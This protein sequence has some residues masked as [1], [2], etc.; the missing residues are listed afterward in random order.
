M[1][2]SIAL[3]L[4][5]PW[6]ALAST[7]VAITIDDLPA[8]GATE[9]GQSRT[10]LNRALID[11][12]AAQKIG[13]VHAFING[14][15][16]DLRN[17]L[18]QVLTDWVA[19][20]HKVANHTHRHIDINGLSVEEYFRDIE[21]DEPLIERLSPSLPRYF[22]FPDLHEGETLPKRTA[23]RN[24]LK[25]RGYQLAHVTIDSRDWAYTEPYIRC[26]QRGDQ[27]A[28]QQMQREYLAGSIQ[29]LRS[30]KTLARKLTR[31]EIPQ[32]LLV[33][34]SAFQSRILGALLQAYL[35]EDVEF[36][37]LS[38][39]LA[40]PIYQIDTGWVSTEGNTFL[41]QLR[42]SLGFAAEP[43]DL[44]PPALETTCG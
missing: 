21:A 8:H 33:H 1:T 10:Q 34:A 7:Q 17:E 43:E 13:G 25:T 32:I 12:L 27:Q 31:R 5:L 14:R 9:H 3:L 30:A 15:G 38:T 39:A 19:A 4:L 26:H 16:V 2:R 20:G 22:R 44:L 23:I 29:R 11:Q 40:D 41:E 37:P 42:K 36:I 24:Y 18:G 28:I 35:R 6:I